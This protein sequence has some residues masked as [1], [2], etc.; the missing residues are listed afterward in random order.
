MLG[1]PTSGLKGLRGLGTTAADNIPGYNNACGASYFEYIFDPMCWGDSF[2]NW[3]AAYTAQGLLTTLAGSAP[4]ANAAPD[5]CMTAISISCP[6]L[7]IGAALGVF[8]IS[9][10]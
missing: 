1:L 10:L 9:K 8:L 3:Q 5:A 7:V 6:V 2:A 4:G